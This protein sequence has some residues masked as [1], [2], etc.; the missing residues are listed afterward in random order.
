MPPHNSGL[1]HVCIVTVVPGLGD[2]L[3]EAGIRYLM[4]AS[5]PVAL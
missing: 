4:Q 2:G 5:E 3:G 1:L